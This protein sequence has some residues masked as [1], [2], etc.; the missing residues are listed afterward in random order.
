M[1]RSGFVSDRGRRGGTLLD[2]EEKML[3]AGMIAPDFALESD[4][5]GVVRLSDFR[6]KTVVVYFY[7]R[8]D[9]PGCTKEACGFRD[10]FDG[11][12]EKGA[13]VI[14]VSPDKPAAHGRFRA[15]YGLQF[16]LLADPD[17]A[18]LEAYGAWGEKSM[19]GRKYEG[20]IRS[21]VVIGPDGAVRKVFPKVKPEGHA[22][23]ILILL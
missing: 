17:H 19:Y 8:D 12:L 5:A 15:K 4:T 1:R 23:E 7:P 13:V 22:E 11:F 2:T 18:V 10:A 9:T 6:G 21:T 3:E 20:V 14:G 16:L